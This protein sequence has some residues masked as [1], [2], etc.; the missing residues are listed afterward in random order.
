MKRNF[1]LAALVGVAL[2]GCVNE[3]VAPEA[4]QKDVLTFSAPV[5]ATQSRAN[6]MGEITGVKYPQGESF[7][8]FCKIYQDKYAGVWETAE[9]GFGICAGIYDAFN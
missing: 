6:V 9:K 5:M 3:E 1:W 7:R 8:V 4:M 2:T